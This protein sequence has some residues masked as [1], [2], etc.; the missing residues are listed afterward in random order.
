MCIRDRECTGR[1]VARSR[2]SWPGCTCRSMSDGEDALEVVREDR[3][4]QEPH[5]DDDQQPAAP[6]LD[7]RCLSLDALKGGLLCPRHGER[8]GKHEPDE[9]EPGDG[10]GG[11]RGGE[12]ADGECVAGQTGQDGTLSLIH[13]SEPTRRTPISYA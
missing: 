10:E 3:Q 12:S 7:G 6:A 2:R 9:H 13:I 5:A 8:G 1:A 11:E 4:G